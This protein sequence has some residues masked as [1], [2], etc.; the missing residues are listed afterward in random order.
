MLARTFVRLVSP[1][2][3]VSYFHRIAMLTTDTSATQSDKK[4]SQT[5]T[6]QNLLELILDDHKEIRAFCKQVQSTEPKESIKWLHQLTWEVA[7]HSVAEE[8]ILYPLMEKEL[9]DEGRRMADSSRYD[10]Q[11]TKEDLQ[12]LENATTLEDPEYMSRYVRMADELLEHLDKEER[13]DI[14]H[15]RKF[16]SEELLMEAAKDFKRTKHFVPTRPHPE[17]SQ[18]PLFETPYSL[19][20]TPIDKLRDMFRS[21]PDHDKVEEVEAR[22]TGHK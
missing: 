3:Q 13:D 17:M 8:L 19:I 14:A 11:R 18:K 21:F 7:R 2:L 12:F 4:P 9:G 1:S 22:A 16:V 5:M 20:V 15:V 10:H 6:K